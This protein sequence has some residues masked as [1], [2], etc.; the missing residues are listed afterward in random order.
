MPRT[1][2]RVAQGPA[3][4]VAQTG[5]VFS[6]VLVDLVAFFNALSSAQL[7]RLYSSSGINYAYV[8]ERLGDFWA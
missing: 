5:L 6:F 8:R 2:P 4:P 7:A 1:R 3:A